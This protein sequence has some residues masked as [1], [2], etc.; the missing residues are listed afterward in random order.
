MV[1][2]ASARLV[3]CASKFQHLT[4]I[5]HDVLYWLLVMQQIKYKLKMV[6]LTFNYIHSTEP[7]YY[8]A[9]CVPVCLSCWLRPTCSQLTEA[10]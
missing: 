3:I 6:T 5:L 4:P 7:S 1:M 9:V 8:I 2:N 10:T